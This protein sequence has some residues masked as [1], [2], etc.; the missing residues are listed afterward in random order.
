MQD[1]YMLI[2]HNSP[3][4][5]DNSEPLC[6]QKHIIEMY[7]YICKYLNVYNKKYLGI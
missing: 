7:Q 5:Y 1:K 2:K 6:T 4:I 3:G